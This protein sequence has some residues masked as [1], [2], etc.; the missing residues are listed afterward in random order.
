MLYQTVNGWLRRVD[1]ATASLPGARL[2]AV[3]ARRPIQFWA[4]VGAI[5][6]L[7]QDHILERGAASLPEMTPT[8]VRIG[9]VLLESRFEPG[10]KRPARLRALD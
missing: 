2:P 3:G 4:T 10:P 6:E 8:L 1:H 9:W 7:V 5:G